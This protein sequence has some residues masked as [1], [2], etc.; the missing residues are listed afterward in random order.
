LEY[1]QL[2]H[3]I[4]SLISGYI[5]KYILLFWIIMGQYTDY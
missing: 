2:S 5:E 3:N 1:E 4:D